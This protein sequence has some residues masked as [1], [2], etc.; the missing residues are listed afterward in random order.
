M[1]PSSLFG[2]AAGI[3]GIVPFTGERSQ[4]GYRLNCFLVSMRDPAKRQAFRDDPDSLMAA[5]GLSHEERSLVNERDYTGML[6]HGASVYAIGKAS[7]ALG[8]TLLD[9]GASQRGMTVQAFV[10]A[11]R[12]G[13]II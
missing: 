8:S 9:I 2:P 13:K 3:D 4:R 11:R 12:G 7:G 6:N 1:T 10:C 5:G